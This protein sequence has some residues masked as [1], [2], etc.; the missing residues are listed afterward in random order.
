MSH[1]VIAPL[2]V[3]GL[4]GKMVKGC[5]AQGDAQSTSATAGQFD[6]IVF[7]AK[8]FQPKPDLLTKIKPAKAL[9]Y[10]PFEDGELTKGELQI[11]TTA[12]MTVADAFD[13]GKKVLVTCMQGRNRSGLVVALAL[14]MIYGV[15]GVKARQIIRE[16]RAGVEVL[17]NPAF[18]RF[19]ENLPPRS[20]IQTPSQFEGLPVLSLNVGNGR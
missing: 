2:E 13:E 18:D 12:A 15:G 1:D 9:V 3:F 17:M 14:H 4:D 11:A 7:C 19:L 6:M 10:A 8:E 5:I 20:I 16:R